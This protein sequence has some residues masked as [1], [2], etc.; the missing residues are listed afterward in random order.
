MSF[1]SDHLRSLQA[2]KFT[3]H[4]AI[5]LMFTELGSS[6]YVYMVMLGVYK[7]AEE[8]GV[9]ED[10]RTRIFA[11]RQKFYENKYTEKEH[12]Q[13]H[14]IRVELKTIERFLGIH[15]SDESCIFQSVTNHCAGLCN[16]VNDYLKFE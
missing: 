16:A 9:M 1:G 5:E 3:E 14:A 7:R 15:K 13:L 6:L 2:G 12:T 10:L 11:L 8:S 4:L